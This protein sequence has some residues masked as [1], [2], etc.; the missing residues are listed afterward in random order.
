[1]IPTIVFENTSFLVIDKPSG[2]VVHPFDNSTE[3]TLVDFLHEKYP[4][5]FEIDNSITLQDGRIIPLGG[6]VHKLDRDTSGVLVVAKDQNTFTE[7][8][9]QFKGHTTTKKYIAL[10]EGVIEKDEFTVDAP[11]GRNKKE[12]KQSTIP[13]NPRG[14]FRDAITE[15]KVLSRNSAT[16]LVEL[17]PKTG[18]THQLRAHMSSIEHPIVGDVAYGASKKDGRILLHA[19]ELSFTIGGQNFTFS[20]P[21]PI[22]FK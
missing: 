20:S 8:Q 9:S 1:M 12:Y 3:T 19:Q 2:L 18:R 21:T 17:M 7:L 16:T 13:S 10:V 14:E 15:V 6:I 5:M 4:S 22:E 11:L